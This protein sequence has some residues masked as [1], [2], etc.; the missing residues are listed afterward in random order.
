MVCLQFITGGMYVW[1]LYASCMETSIRLT[2]LFSSSVYKLWVH[3]NAMVIFRHLFF[4]KCVSFRLL[5]CSIILVGHF[6]G[7]TLFTLI[8]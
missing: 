2:F 4:N 7:F 5:L 6:V 1:W 8:V 3:Y